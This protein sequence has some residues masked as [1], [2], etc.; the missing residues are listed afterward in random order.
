MLNE[1]S[2]SPMLSS[3]LRDP[4][5]WSDFQSDIDTIYPSGKKHEYYLLR[6]RLRGL[7]YLESLLNKT[8]LWEDQGTLTTA[9]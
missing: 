8:V 5:N 4:A 6:T 2:R 9:L 3:I 1:T 7:V